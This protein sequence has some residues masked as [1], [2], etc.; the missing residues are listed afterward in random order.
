[1][2]CP[3]LRLKEKAL[4]TGVVSYRKPI[5]SKRTSELNPLMG[6]AFGWSMSSFGASSI[7][8]TRSAAASPF[9]MA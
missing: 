3:F 7:S 2:V 4:S 9:L 1:M 5:L 8:R 6:F